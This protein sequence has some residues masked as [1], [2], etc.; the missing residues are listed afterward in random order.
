MLTHHSRILFGLVERP[1]IG[2]RELD[3]SLSSNSKHLV[4]RYREID[5]MGCCYFRMWENQGKSNM[6][7]HGL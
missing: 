7:M 4:A 1:L 3:G 5:T 2:E 6:L